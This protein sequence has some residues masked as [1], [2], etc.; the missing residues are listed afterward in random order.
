M[1]GS[2]AGATAVAASARPAR[3]GFGSIAAIAVAILAAGALVAVLGPWK[4]D[5]RAGR[6][7]R[8]S[9]SAPPGTTLHYPAEAELSSDGRAIAFVADD[10]A[11]I[12][13][14]YVLAL[15]APEA[16]VVPGTERGTCPFWAPDGHALGFFADGKLEKVALDGSGPAML[17]DAPDGRGGTW[18][19]DGVI[20]FAPNRQGSIARVS[21]SGG[22]PTPVTKIDEKRHEYGHRY[23]E[24]LPD[25]RHFLY[26]AVGPKPQYTT[27]AASRDGGDPVEVC[28]AGSAVRFAPPGYLLHLDDYTQVAPRRLLA[29]R[30]DLARLKATGDPELVLDGARSANISYPNIAVDAFG[31]LVVQHFGIPHFQLNWRDRSGALLGVAIPDQEVVNS[32]ALSPDQRRLAYCGSDPNDLSVRDLAT[33]VSR[34]LT[35]RGRFVQNMV[36]S[37]DGKQIAYST[38]FGSPHYQIRLKAADGSGEDSLVFEG[39]GLFSTPLSW[40][41]DGRWLLALCSDSTGAMDLWR[42]PM[43]GQGKP[44]PFQLTREDESRGS[45]SPDGRWV[46]YVVAERGKS[47]VYVQRFPDPGSKYQVA[48]EDV[49]D[50]GWCDRGDQLLVVNSKGELFALPVTTSP[51]FETGVPHKIFTAKPPDLLV[52]IAPGEQRFLTGRYNPG[53]GT[54]TLEIVLG[55]QKLLGKK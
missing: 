9:I 13:R 8:F 42:I 32:V 50:A 3:R 45:L 22:T 27:F 31:D 10:S 46:V 19:R 25:G 21:E 16:R 33:G 41:R 20:L 26:V 53:V 34:R 30:F 12:S 49:V 36:W 18:S 51:T 37:H 55:W 2:S 40:S 54:P 5:P 7:M 47:S 28:T 39:P 38:Q 14:L 23:P 6:L 11:G 24:F 44:A 52:A 35:F 15:S 1:Q 48:V 4:G 17:C 29:R 43:L